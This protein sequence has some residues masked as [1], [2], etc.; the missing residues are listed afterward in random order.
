MQFKTSDQVNISFD[1]TGGEGPVVV[2]LTGYSGIKEEWVNQLEALTDRGFRVIRL[3][4]RS[5]GQ[6]ERTARNLRISRL[7]ADL[8]EL[9]Q[10]QSVE[11]FSMVAHSMGAAVAWAYLSLFGQEPVRSFVIVDESPKLLNDQDWTNGIYN[12]DWDNFWQVGPE[13][14]QHRM[15]VSPVDRHLKR[16]L[17]G[18]KQENPFDSALVRPL[19]LDHLLQDWRGTWQ[20]LTMPQLM[21][22]GE[23]SPLW[24]PGY[25]QF[26]VQDLKSPISLEMVKDSGHLPQL[27]QP[28]VFNSVVIDFLKSH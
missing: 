6:S 9:L 10:G 5:H 12:L 23:Q 19:L 26:C 24:R 11:R 15:T 7:A 8:H 17:A 20:D 13:V 2:L 28:E 18:F 1:D 4:W 25:A 27:E 22:A 21:I 14:V 3:D 16:Y